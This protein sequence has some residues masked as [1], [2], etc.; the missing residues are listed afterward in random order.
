MTILFLLKKKKST[1]MGIGFY[2]LSI[3]IIVP[4]FPSPFPW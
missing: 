1:K 3:S 2:K 4:T